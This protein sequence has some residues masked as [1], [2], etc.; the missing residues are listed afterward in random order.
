MAPEGCVPRCGAG[1]LIA[2]TIGDEIPVS[3]KIYGKQDRKRTDLIGFVKSQ[4]VRWPITHSGGHRDTL[5]YTSFSSSPLRL[6]MVTVE[7]A[8][9][10]PHTTHT[11]TL[12]HN[13]TQK[14][15]LHP[16]G[17]NLIAVAEL[18]DCPVPYQR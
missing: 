8:T 18:W 11:L 14:H 4:P 15:L 1:H 16:T 5:T 17:D 6:T 10:I 12:T 13:G 2:P 9:N 3:G 7:I